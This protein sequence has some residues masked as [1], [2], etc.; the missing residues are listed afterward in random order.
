MAHIV[1]SPHICSDLTG[2]MDGSV[3]MWEFGN[4]R[5]VSTQIPPGFG[6]SVTMIR[7][8]PEGNKVNEFQ[9]L[10]LVCTVKLELLLPIPS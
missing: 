10:I 9:S 1:I 3:V 5:P 4:P 7:F 6:A 8:T 2:C